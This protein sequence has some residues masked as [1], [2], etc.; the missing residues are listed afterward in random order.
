MPQPL[1]ATPLPLASTFGEPA[2]IGPDIALAS[3]ARRAELD[4]PPF[5]IHADPAHLE[6]RARALGLNV[7]VETAT[8]ATATATFARALPVVPL[9]VTVTAEPGKP[10]GTSAAA[11]IA[12]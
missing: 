10:D 8:P 2:G 6:R 3:W 1:A 4:L 12:S 11:A 7:P 9:G 5:Y